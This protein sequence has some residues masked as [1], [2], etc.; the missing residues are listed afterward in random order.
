MIN[1]EDAEKA[2]AIT[3]AIKDSIEDL[4][5]KRLV[6]YAK[7]EAAVKKANQAYS[8]AQEEIKEFFEDFNHY[9]WPTIYGLPIPFSCFDS[10]SVYEINEKSVTV[11]L[12]YNDRDNESFCWD[13]KIPFD[14]NDLPMMIAGFK[15]YHIS[16][17]KKSEAQKEEK[18]L[19]KEKEEFE[20]LKK[21]FGGE[22]RLKFEKV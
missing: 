2:V 11:S 4:K 10:F 17:I 8:D 14:E 7:M 20:R 18:A 13:I 9:I 22:E 1:R 19:E 6:F 21:K 12:V 16:K 15:E 5:Q 3:I